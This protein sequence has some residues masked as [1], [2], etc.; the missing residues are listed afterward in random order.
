MKRIQAEQNLAELLLKGQLTSY[1]AH[2]IGFEITKLIDR[3][4]YKPA[5]KLNYF[6]LLNISRIEDIRNY[7]VFAR[8]YI[9]PAEAD[10]VLR[11]MRIWLNRRQEVFSRLPWKKLTV[12]IDSHSDNVFYVNQQVSFIDIYPPKPDWRLLEPAANIIR[13]ATDGLVLAGES[14]YAGFL[15]GYFEYYQDRELDKNLELFYQL[16]SVM[17]RAIYF[18]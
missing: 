17:I 1:D 12:A 10:K 9:S 2:L 3:F 18:L 8:P 14:V 16:G 7:A 4:P 11:A 5:T 13:L 6:E 15:R